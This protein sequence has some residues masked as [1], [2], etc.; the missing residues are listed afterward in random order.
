MITGMQTPSPSYIG[1]MHVH[2]ICEVMQNTMLLGQLIHVCEPNEPVRVYDL[3]TGSVVVFNYLCGASVSVNEGSNVTVCAIITFI[4]GS[5]V[6]P[7][8]L[9]VHFYETNGTAISKLINTPN[10]LLFEVLS[11]P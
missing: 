7:N 4:N 2:S 9:S 8:E 6:L 10:Y 1:C 11:P 3:S 5:Q